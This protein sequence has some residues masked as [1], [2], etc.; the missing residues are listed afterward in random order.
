MCLKNSAPNSMRHD[1]RLLHGQYSQTLLAIANGATVVFI[2]LVQGMVWTEVADLVALDKGDFK[3]Q[4][5]AD[6]VA[7]VYNALKSYK[8][9]SPE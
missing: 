1:S 4:S 6:K 5:A 9:K 7:T 3:G 2:P 8:F